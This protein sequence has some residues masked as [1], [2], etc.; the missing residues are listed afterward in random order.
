VTF[1]KEF[2]ALW[3]L[4]EKKFAA[5]SKRRAEMTNDQ[6]VAF[7]A[8]VEARTR[9]SPLPQKDVRYPC[10]GPLEHGAMVS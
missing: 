8:L 6:Q 9:F 10:L 3:A 2:E 4:N 5:L 7:D 1:K